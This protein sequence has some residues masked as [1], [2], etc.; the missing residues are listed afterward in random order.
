M[1]ALSSAPVHWR[2][3]RGGAAGL[4]W[5]LAA[6]LSTHRRS[7]AED[8]HPPPWASVDEGGRARPS[9]P[10]A[11]RPQ[12]PAQA[13]S[14]EAKGRTL[15]PGTF[16]RYTLS[17]SQSVVFRANAP[18]AQLPPP[19]RFDLAGDLRVGLSDAGPE[20]VDARLSFTATAFSVN[21]GGEE[22]LAP[23]DRRR[24]LSALATP[25]FVTLDRAGAV[26]LIHFEHTVD[27]LVQGLLRVVVAV[28]QVVLPSSASTPWE[29]QEEDSTG[30]YLAQYR[31]EGPLQIHKSK[32]R[33]TDLALGEG[34]TPV[35][36][37]LVAEVEG[38]TTLTLAPEDLWLASLTSDEKLTVNAGSD[39]AIPSSHAR[40]EL[41]LVERGTDPSVVGTFA[42]RKN[43]LF[44]LPMASSQLARPE[45]PREAHRKALAGRSLKDFVRILRARPLDKKTKVARGET[46]QVRED[47]WRDA[48]GG[49][50]ALFVLEPATAVGVPELV[51]NKGLR[52]D[53][54]SL[55][56]GALS[57]AATPEALHALVVIAAD[58][59][60]PLDVRRDAVEC[61]SGAEAP[62]EESVS[63]LWKLSRGPDAALRTPAIFALGST[64]QHLQSADASA[65]DALVENLCRTLSD[66]R[67]DEAQARWLGALGNTRNPR[68]LPSVQTFAR[69]SSPEVRAAAVEGLRFL[70]A[71][72]ADQLLSD[73]L[74]FDDDPKVRNAA[75]FAA[76]FRPLDPLLP[77]VERALHTDPVSTVRTALVQ[78]LGARAGAS[79]KARRL[80]AWSRQEDPDA[81]VRRE[82]ATAL[83]GKP[84]TE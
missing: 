59:R 78:L 52:T 17:S 46:D 51:R 45:D 25:F 55:V 57:A 73:R 61:L 21:I 53:A 62:T 80:L 31:R 76:S 6:G 58:P 56:L 5:V 22:R 72:E 44:S 49:L 40:V 14:L 8:L 54:L 43:D 39:M 42:A 12:T 83:G 69:A 10:P 48:A 38:H 35:G 50:H 1:P 19:M 3:I 77:A 67:G 84:S 74:L 32:L 60:I 23:E 30:R 28:S 37:S 2:L 70:P 41:R 15:L 29:T 36:P 13:V 79:P 7:Q 71:P 4:L 47:A 24:L 64:A 63:A 9:L 16:H 20:S 68:A 81:S 11:L 82:A 26:R 34:L 66:A 75:V 33:Y 18:D 27:V 65:A